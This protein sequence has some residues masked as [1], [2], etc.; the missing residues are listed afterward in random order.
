MLSLLSSPFY[1]FFS[2]SYS[3]LEKRFSIG[4]TGS[5]QITNNAHMSRYCRIFRGYQSQRRHVPS[6]LALYPMRPVT[7]PRL[8]WR[9]PLLWRSTVSNELLSV[10]TLTSVT[11]FSMHLTTRVESLEETTPSVGRLA[12]QARDLHGS[13]PPAPK[14]KWD[15]TSLERLALFEHRPLR[16]H[17]RL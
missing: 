12:S 1:T 8:S 4:R 9:L 6:A 13:P 14:P 3:F 16:Q 5:M 15:A 17:A 11:R 10:Q 7:C 2:F